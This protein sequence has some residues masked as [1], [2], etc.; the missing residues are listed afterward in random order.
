MKSSSIFSIIKESKGLSL[1]FILSIIAHSSIFL[2]NP[3]FSFTV[4]SKWE[5][6]K[7]GFLMVEL[8][9]KKD[10]A[11]K[12]TSLLQPGAI[13]RRDKAKV[14]I[15]SGASLSSGSKQ[16]GGTRGYKK[17]ALKKRMLQPKILKAGAAIQVQTKKEAHKDDGALNKAAKNTEEAAAKKEAVNNPA[18]GLKN[19][20]RD[21]S[22]HEA[23]I[24][25]SPPLEPN[26]GA[27]TALASLSEKEDITPDQPL[28]I[29]SSEQP[30]GPVKEEVTEGDVAQTEP[31]TETVGEDSAK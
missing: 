28:N 16:A 23:A 26:K 6:Q 18:E 12:K 3:T 31:L 5:E 1:F 2:I 29:A 22:S 9:D 15:G 20:V 4:G 7:T 19:N 24:A 21:D 8:K 14:G 30:A 25:P 10:E 11:G 13:P 27:E 17:T